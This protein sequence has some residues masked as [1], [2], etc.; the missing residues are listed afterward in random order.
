M[1]RLD[2]VKCCALGVC[3][4]FVPVSQIASA[5]DGEAVK[6]L[7]WKLDAARIRYSKLVT[8]LGEELDPATAKK[9]FHRLGRECAA[10]FR[11]LT[12]DKYSGDI[13]GFL[14][15]VQQPS[16]WVREAEYDEKNGTIR[17]VDRH[18]KCTCPLV[19][20]GLTSADQCQCT[21][22][23]QEETYSRILGKPVKAEVEESILRGG[24]RCVF[25]I[26][27]QD[28]NI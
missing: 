2:F 14:A 23:W 5:D 18:P 17:V 10:Q 28:A 27:I 9:I 11:S 25:R 4:T 22:G 16:G 26:Q 1:E 12:F 3:A 24:S 7:Q 20:E 6:A 15:A 19:Q 21:L 13:K 8:I